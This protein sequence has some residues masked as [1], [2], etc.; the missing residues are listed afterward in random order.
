MPWADRARPEMVRWFA[1]RELIRTSVE[2]LSAHAVAW[3][4]D[5]RVVFG[6]RPRKAGDTAGGGKRLPRRDDASLDDI[7]KEKKEIWFDYVSD[8]GDGFDSTYA[9]ARTLAADELRLSP[10]ACEPRSRPDAPLTVTRR[11]DILVLGGDL[12]YP[13]PRINNYEERLVA[14]YNEAAHWDRD[15][16][17][18]YVLAIPGNH[19]WYDGLRGFRQLFCR[20]RGRF[21]GWRTCQ[22]RSYFAVRL[23]H[24][25]WLIGADTQLSNAINPDQAD[26]F[27]SVRQ[28]IKAHHRVILCLATP[29]WLEPHAATGASVLDV[30][31]ELLGHDIDVCLAGHRHHY[32]RHSVIEKDDRVESPD[33]RAPETHRLRGRDEAERKADGEEWAG[34]RCLSRSLQRITAGGGGTYMSPTHVPVH[35][36]LRNQLHRHASFPPPSDS[37]R[38]RRRLFLLPF[39]EPWFGAIP[40][41]IYALGCCIL[42][43]LEADTFEAFRALARDRAETLPGILFVVVLALSTLMLRQRF[44]AISLLIAVIHSAAHLVGVL[45]VAYW[46]LPWQNTW[47][48]LPVVLAGGLGWWLG[49]A[50]VGAYLYVASW[51]DRFVDVGYAALRIDDWKSFL[52]F[53]LDENGNLTIYPIGLRRVPRTWSRRAAPDGDRALRPEDPRATAPELIE[54]PILIPARRRNR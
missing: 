15:D 24:D 9:I 23:P 12:T 8:L 29:D 46:V 20:P 40:A 48:F 28:E 10:P 37:L 54:T 38:Y 44:D 22:W 4:V 14:P 21:A 19:D 6:G 42:L 51:F 3:F 27:E 11:A 2:V 34:A 52:R 7:F 33:D 47:R 26:Y 35:R 17:P 16:D 36:S 53:H 41:V 5:P 32:Q 18:P 25:V 39:L 1:P 30:M 43:G 31:K 45:L 13:T 50:I 49:A